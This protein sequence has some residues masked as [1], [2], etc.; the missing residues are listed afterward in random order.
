MKP[1]ICVS[2]FC[3]NNWMMWKTSFGP[4]VDRC[5]T[6]LR[7]RRAVA[8]GGG[9]YAPA[10][11]RAALPAPTAESYS[12]TNARARPARRSRARRAFILRPLISTLQPRLRA[13]ACSAAVPSALTASPTSDPPRA[14][15]ARAVN[16]PPSV[17]GARG[18]MGEQERMHFSTRECACLISQ[19][20]DCNL[21]Y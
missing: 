7:Q 1:G 17:R 13:N 5:D 19:T 6:L 16:D 14:A 10:L 3:F 2:M 8:G 18:E 21:I 12:H 15:R 4:R 11:G 9:R 20:C